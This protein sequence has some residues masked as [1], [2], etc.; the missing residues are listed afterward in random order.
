MQTYGKTQEA[1]KNRILA[2]KLKPD[3]ISTA[4]EVD[5]IGHTLW[6][7]DQFDQ[8]G[9]QHDADIWIGRIQGV[10]HALGL[11]TWVELDDLMC[12]DLVSEK[13][14]LASEFFDPVLKFRL[15]VLAVDG[16]GPRFSDDQIVQMF[17]GIKVHSE[18]EICELSALVQSSRPSVYEKLVK[19]LRR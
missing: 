11:F 10:A 8:F 3:V 1:I 6:R 15:A 18:E 14:P 16:D 19:E 7:L 17:L 9:N 2:L 12:E 4:N 13:N 5:L